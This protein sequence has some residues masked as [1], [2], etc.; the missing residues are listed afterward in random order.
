MAWSIVKFSGEEIIN[1]AI[2]IEKAGKTFYEAMKQKVDN[3][4]FKELFAFLAGEEEQH[5]ADFE[6]LGEKL[7]RDVVPNESYV[8]EYGDY[9]RAVIDS[10]I[11]NQKNVDELVKDIV[12]IREALAIAFRFEKDS[13]MI[14]QEFYNG[15]DE[16]G[17][18]VIGKLIDEE[19]K[20]I[21]KLSAVAR[22]LSFGS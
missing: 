8:G 12:D 20:H 11:F 16:S 15:A 4:E 18:E 3:P 2:E 5:V 7:T 17:K 9:L 13:I 21:K 22:P 1:L 10:H 14:F 6:K 19:R